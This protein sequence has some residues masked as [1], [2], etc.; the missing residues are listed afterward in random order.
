MILGY[1]YDTFSLEGGTKYFNE[2]QRIVN[3]A[4]SS[5]QTGWRSFEDRKN[6]FWLVAN[7]LNVRYKPLRKAYYEYHRKG[8]DLMHKNMNSSRGAITKTLKELKPIHNVE[9]SSYN[10]QVFFNAKMPEVVKLYE[11]ASPQ[12][13]QEMADLFILIDPG[14]AGEYEKMRK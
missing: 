7:A 1:D 12:E 14:N 11:K 2:A 5:A 4:Q 10:M 13:K 6:R 8:F 3:N 9:P